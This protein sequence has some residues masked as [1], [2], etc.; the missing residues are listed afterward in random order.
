MVGLQTFIEATNNVT[1]NPSLTLTNQQM[2][3]SIRSNWR[4]RCI[5]RFRTRQNRDVA[6]GFLNALKQQYGKETADAAA[7][8]IRLDRTRA[9][10]KPLRARQVT[11]ATRQAEQQAAKTGQMNRHL[12]D[13]YE[14]NLRLA[15][16]AG[17][18]LRSVIDD[19]AR[20]GYGGNADVAGLLDYPGLAETVHDAIIA[21]GK[22]GEA[23]CR[24]IDRNRADEICKEIVNQQ[25]HAAYNA[26]RARALHKLDPR[27]PSSFTHRELVRVLA[28]LGTPCGV[29]DSS[30]SP[31]A[32]EH[33][34]RRFASSIDSR[35]IRP[36]E[37][38]DDGA[39][40]S[41]ARD[42]VAQFKKEREAALERLRGLSYVEDAERNAFLA[43]VSRDTVAPS[44]VPYLAFAHEMLCERLS[45]LASALPPEELHSVIAYALLSIQSAWDHAGIEVTADNE[46]RLYRETWRFLLAPLP[47]DMVV[48][49]HGHYV[50]DD[51]PARRIGEAASWYATEFG[52]SRE[53]A[54]T[55]EDTEGRVTL[56]HGE[57]SFKLA[58]G[59]SN[60]LSGLAAVLHEKISPH[61]N[62]APPMQRLERP[63]DQTVATLRNLG[64]PF[65]AP[66]RL[67]C[68]AVDVPLSEPAMA[69][70]R[71]EFAWHI[72]A[73]RKVVRNGNLGAGMTKNFMDFLAANEQVRQQRRKACFRV[74]GVDLPVGAGTSA[75]VDALRRFCMDDTDEVDEKLLT[76]ISQA[77]SPET[78]RC[79]YA[80][81]M[82]PRRPDLAIL[83]GYPRGVHEEHSYSLS[84]EEDGAVRLKITERITPLFFHPV[85]CDTVLPDSGAQLQDGNHPPAEIL[86]GVQS[87]FRTE[88]FVSFGDRKHPPK[89]EQARISYRLTP[90]SPQEPYWI[91]LN[92]QAVDVHDEAEEASSDSFDSVTTQESDHIYNRLDHGSSRRQPTQPSAV[93]SFNNLAA[94]PGPGS[95]RSTTSS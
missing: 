18:A 88:V 64:I 67:N 40:Q 93:G 81:C 75:V 73:C 62:Q 63:G 8:S 76:R 25:L 36:D 87:D 72:Q 45:C 57:D 69:E 91:S 30:I 68:A 46:Q 15:D 92:S 3:V 60:M 61:A 83:N 42:V 85:S 34:C 95:L 1:G 24:S 94:E 80:A 86:N 70:M 79:V 47:P 55:Y 78:L 19:A 54:R 84:K 89:I 50:A 52:D 21:E 27:V 51:G 74:D 7:R 4:A 38:V 48:S 16:G 49:I 66:D 12:A 23:G 43:Q 90:G 13:Y 82:D 77:A 44:L 37:L 11:I 59:Y 28:D 2:G 5:E 39:L 20:T 14:I 53:A 41:L 56:I 32:A 26:A 33:L 29:A 6:T 35:D 65:P 71:S 17:S 58:R 10:G 31:D 22:D 9:R